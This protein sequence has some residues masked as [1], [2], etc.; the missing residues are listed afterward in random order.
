MPL[1]T[2]HVLLYRERIQIAL[3]RSSPHGLVV[4]LFASLL[5]PYS[6]EAVAAKVGYEPHLVSF[7]IGPALYAF[8]DG[9]VPGLDYFTQYSVGL[10]W[11]FS[12]FLASTATLTLI[13][14]V[15]FIAVSMLLFYVGSFYLLQ[16]R[17]TSTRCFWTGTD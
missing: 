10:G 9:L 6:F 3:R 1:E 13:N 14:Y 2:A 4:L 11:V 7:L 16:C 5:L 12:F 15:G 8:G 17:R